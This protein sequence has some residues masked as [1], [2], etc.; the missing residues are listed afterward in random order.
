MADGNGEDLG[1]ASGHLERSDQSIVGQ[2][3]GL[4]PFVPAGLGTLARRRAR[5][6]VRGQEQIPKV[7]MGV[8]C[9]RLVDIEMDEAGAIVGMADHQACLLF[10]LPKGGIPRGLLRVDVAT[11]LHPAVEAL[12]EMED[13]APSPHDDGRSGQVDGVGVL[14]ERSGQ[15]VQR[16]QNQF[17]GPDLPGIGCR[18]T[19]DRFSNGGDETRGPATFLSRPPDASRHACIPSTRRRAVREVTGGPA[20]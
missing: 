19:A 2:S 16:A 17:L 6:L 15:A 12:V 9:G 20:P 7:E 13:G 10:R 14:V 8:A 1:L 5:I 18:V 4:V 3:E 11:G